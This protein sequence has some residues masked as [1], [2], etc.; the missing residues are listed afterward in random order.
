MDGA[1]SVECEVVP[2]VHLRAAPGHTPGHCVVS[3]SGGGSTLT[4]L[5]DAIIDELQ[6]RHLNWVCAFD[7]VA[8]QTVRTRTRLLAEAA[9]SGSDLFAYHVG[10]GFGRVSTAG[11]GFTWQQFPPV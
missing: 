3:V 6:F 8:D 2:G 9:E 10:G 11:E 7:Q 5:A 4:L 1:G